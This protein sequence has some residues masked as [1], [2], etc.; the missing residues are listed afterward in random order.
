M[1]QEKYEPKTDNPFQR[2]LN[3]YYPEENHIRDRYKELWR[4][5]LPWKQTAV[6]FAIL[7]GTMLIAFVITLMPTDGLLWFLQLVL[8]IAL[9]PAVILGIFYVPYWMDQRSAKPTPKKQNKK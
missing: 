9:I 3:K 7:L 5:Y 6:L 8:L 2:W 1:T 4:E